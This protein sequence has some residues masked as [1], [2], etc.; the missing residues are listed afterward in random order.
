MAIF[1][2]FFGRTIGEAAAFAL[3]G[4]MRSPLEPPLVELTNETWSKFVDQGI[5]VPTDPGDAAEIAAERVS[6]RPWAKEQAKQRG[7]GG[8]QMDKLIDA[9]MNA[10]GIGELFQ[11][12]RRRLITDAQFEHGLRKARLEDLWDGPL[13]GLHDTLLSSE[14]LAMLQQQGFVDESRANAEGELQGV[15]SERQQLRFEASGLP[16]GIETALQML[17]RSIIDG[18]TFAQIV[19]EGHTKTKY[20]D[21]LAQLKD[22]VL[23]AL[24]YVE[25][26]LRAWITE[27][28]MNA[29]GALTGH[30]P[31]QMDLLFKIHG[32]PISF[33]QTWIGLQRGGTLDGPIGDIHPAFLA[34]LRRSNVQPPFYNLAWAQR[35]NYPSAFVLRALTQSGDLTEAQT[36]EILKFEGWEPTLRAT[37]AKKWATAKGAAAKEASASDLLALYDGEK[38]TRAETLTGLEALGY[39]ANE[40]AAKLATLDARRVTSARNAAISDLH[41]AFK[42]GSLTAAMVEPALAK[43]VNEPGSAPQILAA[44]QAYMDAFP[45]PSAPV[46]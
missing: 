21:E 37:V 45:P 42:K 18:G 24:N 7:Y 44:W 13:A 8:E 12:W 41:A 33:H 23:P 17:R 14:E 40:A 43:L 29:G 16:P 1:S 38:A 28:E 27:G 6:D 5:T 9:V 35:Y 15:T 25:G 30:T 20:T 3:G 32:R 31:E 36:E 10:P 39:P 26:H 46:V 22:V 4:A 34:S 19:R 2:K 11:L